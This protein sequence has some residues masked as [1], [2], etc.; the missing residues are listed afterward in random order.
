[1]QPFNPELFYYAVYSF[2]PSYKSEDV[3]Y[4]TY[5]KK[6]DPVAPMRYKIALDI[7][8]GYVMVMAAWKGKY[9]LEPSDLE[10]ISRLRVKATE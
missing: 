10:Q 8:V 7:M 5:Q 4:L 3:P 6:S 2:L 1:M 9:Q